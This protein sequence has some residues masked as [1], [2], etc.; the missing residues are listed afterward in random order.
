MHSSSNLNL[1]CI[2]YVWKI[3]TLSSALPLLFAL[4]PKILHIKLISYQLQLLDLHFIC[5][6]MSMRFCYVAFLVHVHEF[7]VFMV[8]LYLFWMFL[9]NPWLG[10]FGYSSWISR[11]RL[12]LSCMAVVLSLPDGFCLLLFQ[13]LIPFPWSVTIKYI[14]QMNNSIYYCHRT[15]NRLSS[16]LQFPKILQIVGLGYT[17]WFSTRYLL[18]KVRALIVEPAHM[19]KKCFFFLLCPMFNDFNIVLTIFAG[20]QRWTVC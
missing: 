10:L 20:K 6:K 19:W 4:H 3:Q 13:Q 2:F 14:K 1:Q 8:S 15:W 5:R 18:F 12:L 17:I 11:R 9:W 16:S 7:P